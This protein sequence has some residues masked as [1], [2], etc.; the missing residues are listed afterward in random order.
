MKSTSRILRLTLIACGL[1]AGSALLAVQARRGAAGEKSYIDPNLF[2]PEQ[3]K[4]LADLDAA[5]RASLDAVTQTLGVGRGTAFYDTRVGRWSSLILS[6]P[7]VPGRG[8][9]NELAW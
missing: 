3:T 7:L 6:R 5:T 4:A 9:G 1:L 8:H 2:V